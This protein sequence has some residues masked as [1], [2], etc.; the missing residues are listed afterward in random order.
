RETVGTPPEEGGTDGWGGFAVNDLLI[1]RQGVLWAATAQG[2]YRTTTAVVAVASEESPPG[3]PAEAFELGAPYPNPTREAVTVPLMLAEAAAVHV[4]VYDL[5]GRQV[6]L[7]H[8]GVLVAGSNALAFETTGLPAGV[9]VVR[10]SV[11]DVTET[12]RVTVAR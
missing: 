7:L 6:A 2:V 11:G 10:A 4:A 9:Y 12:R 8:D 3:K 1:D 5:L